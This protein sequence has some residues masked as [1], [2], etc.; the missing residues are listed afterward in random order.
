M[1]RPS[2][3]RRAAA[4]PSLL[5]LLLLGACATVGEGAPRGDVT[6]ELAFWSEAWFVVAEGRPVH[7]PYD[8]GEFAGLE[9]E[10]VR[11]GLAQLASRAPH[12]A[13]VLAANGAVAAADGDDDD[14]SRWLDRALNVDP[15][16]VQAA[17]LRAALAAREGNTARAARLLG[18]A[19]M[20]RPDAGPL[21]EA[22]AGVR[23]LEGRL[24]E[25]RALLDEARRLGGPTARSLWHRGL[26]A[27]ARGDVAGALAAYDALLI[28][29]PDDARA[30]GRRAALPPVP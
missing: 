20:L 12:A 9:R 1:C 6:S 10:D 11:R 13:D 2:V 22:L 16:H 29:E 8:A 25:A 27:E 7:E 14:A 19:R 15:A 23:Y 18:T 4:A 24:D 17:C 21:A 5:L 30:A 28:V 3:V 26:L